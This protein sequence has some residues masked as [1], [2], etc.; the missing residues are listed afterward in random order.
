MADTP[1]LWSIVVSPWSLRVKWALQVLKFPYETVEYDLMIG[2]W[3]LRLN[4]KLWRWGVTVPV[5]FAS[6]AS[7]T[8]GVDIVKYAQAH[9]GDGAQDILV[10]GVDE[11]LATADDRMGMLR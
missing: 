11:W 4:L 3:Q 2:T 8:D 10:D 6:D 1:K 9:K 7:L 5:M